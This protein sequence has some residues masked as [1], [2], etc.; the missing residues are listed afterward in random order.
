MPFFSNV[1]FP[2]SSIISS[3]DLVKQEGTSCMA[4][5]PLKLFL[6]RSC[7][8]TVVL[9]LHN[10]LTHSSS[11]SEMCVLTLVVKK[12]GTSKEE[13]YIIDTD[14]CIWNIKIHDKDHGHLDSGFIRW[15]TTVDLTEASFFFFTFHVKREYVKCK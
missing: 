13:K 6:L 3:L 12:R 7:Q 1:W 9:Y 4:C 2:S 14:T 15:S 5:W 8:S 10:T 11:K